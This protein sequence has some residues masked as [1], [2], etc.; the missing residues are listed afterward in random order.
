MGN[1]NHQQVEVGETLLNVLWSKQIAD[2]SAISTK[3]VI[4]YIYIYMYMEF[5]FFVIFR[6]A[7]FYRSL[8]QP[9][10]VPKPQ[11]PWRRGNDPRG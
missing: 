11:T 5:H 2:S 1:K 10:P 9:T 6:S 4:N 7:H 8:P 3:L